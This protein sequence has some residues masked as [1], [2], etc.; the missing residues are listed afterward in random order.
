M[1]SFVVRKSPLFSERDV[2]AFAKMMKVHPGI[3]AGQ[4]QR[5]TGRWDLFKRL[6]VKIRHLITRA[7]MTDGWGNIAPLQI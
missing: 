6:Q 4:L 7:A 2:I 1:N 3:V 5:K